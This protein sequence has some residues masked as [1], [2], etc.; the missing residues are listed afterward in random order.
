MESR[1][2]KKNSIILMTAWLF[3]TMTVMAR[4]DDLVVDWH[5]LYTSANKISKEMNDKEVTWK[6]F[7]S[8]MSKFANDIMKSRQKGIPL[9]NAIEMDGLSTEEV[10]IWEEMKKIAIQAYKA[11][12]VPHPKSVEVRKEFAKKY[13]LQCKIAL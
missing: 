6:D 7:C 3:V 12:I 10:P 1:M 2:I 4:A 8:N 5:R 13:Y 9:K 11:P